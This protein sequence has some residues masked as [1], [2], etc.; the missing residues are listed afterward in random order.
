M[1]IKRK[2]FLVLFVIGNFV[3]SQNKEKTTSSKINFT[4]ER[5]ANCILDKEGLYADTLSLKANFPDH[6]YKIV[7]NKKEQSNILGF[8]ALEEFSAKDLKK[9]Y[10]ILSH[11]TEIIKGTYDPLKNST[12][13]EVSKDVDYLNASFRDILKMKFKKFNYT[14]KIDYNKKKVYLKYQSVSYNQTFEENLK[15]I[16]FVTSD[17]LKG[18]YTYKVHDRIYKNL[19]ELN[20]DYSDKVTPY[21]LF[22]NT[23]YGVQKI[24]SVEE[25]FDLKSFSKE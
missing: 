16:N 22:S 21:V 17:S 4:Y 24:I 18:N 19:V 7:S 23:E 25:T 1:N 13:I 15:K 2:I 6:K 3:F 20:K 12:K 11:S 10:S 5:R 9:I 8:I 14:V